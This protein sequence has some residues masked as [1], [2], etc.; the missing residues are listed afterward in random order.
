MSPWRSFYGETH[1]GPA[2]RS[3]APVAFRTVVETPKTPATVHTSL[4]LPGPVHD[5]LRKIAYD[6]HIKIHAVV[7]EG[8]DAALKR[9]GYP[10]IESLKAGKK[11]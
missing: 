7:I 10:S 5:A 3:G 2:N 8:I 4:Y 11:R 6:E 1:R 9:R